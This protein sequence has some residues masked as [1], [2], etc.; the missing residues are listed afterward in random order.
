MSHRNDLFAAAA[1]QSLMQ[2]GW[3]SSVIGADHGPAAFCSL[4][5]KYAD[6]MEELRPIVDPAASGTVTTETL[7]GN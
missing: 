2:S 1:L 3:N 4:A 7:P 6:K 5:L